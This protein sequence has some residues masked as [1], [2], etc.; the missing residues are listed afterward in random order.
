MVDVYKNV[1]NIMFSFHSMNIE[2]NI[3]KSPFYNVAQ[4]SDS[5]LTCPWKNST[6]SYS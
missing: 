4:L 6:I 1:K 2:Y 3:E 5:L